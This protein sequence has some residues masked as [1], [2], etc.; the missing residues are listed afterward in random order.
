MRRIGKLK[1][2]R[3]VEYGVRSGL[4]NQYQNAIRK[5][6]QRRN[7]ASVANSSTPSPPTKIVPRRKNLAN[8]RSDSDNTIK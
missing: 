7:R 2:V 1:T 3:E 8:N 6:N 5:L 4:E